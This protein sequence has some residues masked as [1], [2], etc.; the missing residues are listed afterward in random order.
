MFLQQAKTRKVNF[1]CWFLQLIVHG[2][3]RFGIE[4]SYSS[5]SSILSKDP[6][7]QRIGIEIL[8]IKTDYPGYLPFV[9][10]LNP[11]VTK[12]KGSIQFL[13]FT[14]LRVIE[15]MSANFNGTII[16][17]WVHF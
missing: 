8:M 1:R 2:I 7:T 5:I 13:F 17:N 4:I 12:L 11:N 16:F 9:I 14:N 10:F 3:R 15:A 6:A